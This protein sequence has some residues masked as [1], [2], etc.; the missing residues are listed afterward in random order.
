MWIWCRTNPRIPFI[1]PYEIGEEKNIKP[2]HIFLRVSPWIYVFVVVVPSV[3]QWSFRWI[4][5][6]QREPLCTFQDRFLNQAHCISNRADK[7]GQMAPS[8]TV[9]T[10]TVM[11]IP[12]WMHAGYNCHNLIGD[13]IPT[14]RPGERQILKFQH[15]HSALKSAQPLILH[16]SPPAD[17]FK[18]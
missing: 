3:I 8:Q 12:R 16:A 11:L 4:H 9:W 18:L 6:N 5:M 2:D 17:L 1:T 14:V 7:S 10:G 15:L 13:F